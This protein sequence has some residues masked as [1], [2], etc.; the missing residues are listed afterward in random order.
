[1]AASSDNSN[2]CST[3]ASQLPGQIS[4]AQD[5]DYAASIE[6]YFYQQARLGPQC[7]VYPK[8][9]SDISRIVKTLVARQGKAAVR[10][11]GHTPIANAANIENAVTIDLSNMNAVS[12]GA[13]DLSSFQNDTDSSVGPLSSSAGRS[14]LFEPNN[15]APSVSDQ[16]FSN[17]S[18]DTTS[19]KAPLNSPNTL[20]AG[21]GA[22]WGDVYKKLDS[23]GLISIGG[24]GTS[25]G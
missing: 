25:L 13:L 1:M 16:S 14:H 2:L 11:G 23:T 20:S 4:Y 8:S 22:T 3:L 7:I 18:S 5:A 24:R 19:E 6:S 9:T 15:P 10:G 21:G 17:L 12:L